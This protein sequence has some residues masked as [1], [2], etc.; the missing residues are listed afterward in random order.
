[1]KKDF[2]VTYSKKIDEFNET[3]ELHYYHIDIYNNNKKLYKITMEGQKIDLIHK[4]ELKKNNFPKDAKY[5]VIH[6]LNGIITA[7]YK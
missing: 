6:L 2:T 4:N 5:H 7:Y 3:A 1:M